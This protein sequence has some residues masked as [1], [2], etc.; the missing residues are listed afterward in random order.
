MVRDGFSHQH[1]LLTSPFRGFRVGSPLSLC[2]LGLARWLTKHLGL[3]LGVGR[4]LFLH[5]RSESTGVVLE[6]LGPGLLLA[7]A[8]RVLVVY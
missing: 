1:L 6:V 5:K 2:G 3:G 7:L 8:V 4:W